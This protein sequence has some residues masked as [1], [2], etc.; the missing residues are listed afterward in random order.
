MMM[1]LSLRELDNADTCIFDFPYIVWTRGI[2]SYTLH[3]LKSYIKV[4][5]TRS[6]IQVCTLSGLYYSTL[7]DSILSNTH[8]QGLTVHDSFI[9]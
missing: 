3:I 4:T 7:L 6:D 5:L 9:R 8:H 2:D 1:I